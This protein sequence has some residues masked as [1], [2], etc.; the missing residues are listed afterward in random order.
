MSVFHHQFDKIL[1]RLGDWNPQL[2]RELKSRLK[3]RNL[4]LLTAFGVISQVLFY[5]FFRGSLPPDPLLDP[6]TY[7]RYCLGSPPPELNGYRYPY[8]F[9]TSDL[10]GHTVIN[11]QLWWLHL[12]ITISLIGIIILL[13]KGTHLLIHDLAQEESKGTLNFIR[14]S[15]QPAQT[16][17]LGKLLGVPILLYGLAL[18]TLPLHLWAGWMAQIPLPLI[19][20]FYLVLLASCAFFYHVAL[21]IGLM[22]QRLFG[23]Q[24]F[25]SVS[26]VLL[27]LFLLLM[28]AMSLLNKDANFHSPLNWINLFY[29]GQ[30]LGYLV[31]STFLPLS[32][33]WY[34]Q[35]VF[36]NAW[37][38]IGF[39]LINYGIWTYWLTL[40][41]N[42]R[43]R[44]SQKLFLSKIQSYGLTLAFVILGLGFVPQEVGT[45][46][47][48]FNFVIFQF[49]LFG[50]IAV[51]SLTLSPERPMLQLWA[52]YRH[53]QPAQVRHL[54]QDYLLGEQS[55]ANLAIAVN[56]GIIFLYVTPAILLFPLENYRWPVWGELIL[57]LSITGVYA[58]IYQRI[59][60]LNTRKRQL[61][62]LGAVGLLVITPIWGV[63]IS[64]LHLSANANLWFLTFLP[65]IAGESA[66]PLYGLMIVLG[67]WTVMLVCGL[68]MNRHLQKIGRSDT[69]QLHQG[70]LQKSLKLNP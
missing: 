60:L 35:P 38:G 30:S 23:L 53:Q 9:C 59:L 42:R 22:G 56:L 70:L 32:L 2:L 18:M 25:A 45:R 36:A 68:E 58:V 12:F 31:P 41:I 65:M 37:T 44:S 3:A 61:F 15:P 27:L 5:F 55:P 34:G 29:P 40:A 26:S 24:T 64:N 11:W 10:L 8:N 67:E 63:L 16:I 19:L 4:W 14:L 57:G 17:F 28:T 46:Q 33:K 21:L 50:F 20:A 13:V 54:W 43:F 48:Y 1:D 7:N 52:R 62:A 39:M 66:S 51:L 49:L 69:Q 47:L 6:T